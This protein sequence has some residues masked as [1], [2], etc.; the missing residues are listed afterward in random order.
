MN[1]KP[2]E[3]LDAEERELAALLGRSGPHGEPSPALDA[4][5]RAAAHAAVLREAAP[6]P[7]Q[8][9]WP[10]LAGLAASLLLAA[11]IGWQLRPQPATLPAS[12]VPIAADTAPAAGEAA[13]APATDSSASRAVPPAPPPP[14]PPPPIRRLAPPAATATPAPTTEARQMATAQAARA[15]AARAAA[16][17]RVA[18]SA[19]ARLRSA[20]P[21]IEVAEPRP[22]DIVAFESAPPPPA[23]VAAMDAPAAPAP[24]APPAPAA[25][26]AEAAGTQA[27]A[28]AARPAAV[29]K[30]ARTSDKATLDSLVVS[31]N[32]AKAEDDVL[33]IAV[34]EDSRLHRRAWLRRV[35]QRLAQGDRDGARESLR[36]FVEKHPSAAIPDALRGLLKE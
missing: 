11:G 3:P 6:R 32:R 10:T 30:P 31:D 20:A 25:A 22:A 26:Q 24:P 14:P 13:A 27:E 33:G 23:P 36:Q 12:E 2:F 1:R 28:Y 9:R 15:E 7:G 34:S 17:E 4:N 5:I 21:P 29:A 8:R 19:T 16:Q 35:E 18:A